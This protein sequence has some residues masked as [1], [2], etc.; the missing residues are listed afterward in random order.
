MSHEDAKRRDARNVL[1]SGDERKVV[2]LEADVDEDGTGLT[3]IE[4][5]KTF[6]RPGKTILNFT[7]TVRVKIVDVGNS[8]AEAIAVEQVD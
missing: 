5:I 1:S 2:I 4:N 3:K 7:D 6:V 8:H